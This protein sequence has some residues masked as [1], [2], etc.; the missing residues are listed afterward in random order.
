M[1]V[2]YTRV[3]PERY[4]CAFKW[5]CSEK[6]S[7]AFIDAML[8]SIPSA[9]LISDAALSLRVVIAAFDACCKTATA[10]EMHV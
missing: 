2:A 9:Y 1:F 3:S 4:R 7:I 5:G 8:L 10:G 6:V